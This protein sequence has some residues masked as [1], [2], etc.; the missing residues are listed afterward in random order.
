MLVKVLSYARSS[1]VGSGSDAALTRFTTARSIQQAAGAPTSSTTSPNRRSRTMRKSAGLNKIAGTG[2][3]IRV[4]W[5][6]TRC[7]TGS[8]ALLNLF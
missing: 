8:Y 1:G 5:T 4:L 6:V 2:R 7:R 3:M